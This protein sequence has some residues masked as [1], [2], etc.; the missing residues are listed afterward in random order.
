MAKNSAPT[1]PTGLVE[2]LFNSVFVNRPVKKSFHY[3]VHRKKKTL[4][5]K[6][7]VRI[8]N[9]IYYYPQLINISVL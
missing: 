1:I 2:Y 5:I 4:S 6:I 8:D 3:L 9:I 7:D